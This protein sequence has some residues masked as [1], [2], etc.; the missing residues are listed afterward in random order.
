LCN[1]RVETDPREEK[2]DEEANRIS[3]NTPLKR[4]EKGWRSWEKKVYVH[5]GWPA[6]IKHTQGVKG[7]G[8]LLK[9]W[10][11]Q[12]KRGIWRSSGKRK[13]RRLPNLGGGEELSRASVDSVN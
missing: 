3:E 13:G 4:G 6:S 7:K 2:R 11:G 12:G 9:K 10:L 5:R 1:Q 8:V